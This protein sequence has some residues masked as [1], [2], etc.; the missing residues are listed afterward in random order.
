[1][2][3]PRYFAGEPATTVFAF[4]FLVT[5][6]WAPTSAPS[7]ILKPGDTLAVSAITANRET[8]TVIRQFLAGCG[9]FVSWWHFFQL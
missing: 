8:V 5:R 2:V 4:T 9:T 3:S 6:L 7:P 1:L